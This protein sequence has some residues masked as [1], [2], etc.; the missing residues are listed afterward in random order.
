MRIG[1]P[2]P[3]CA[4]G[5]I[6]Q[7]QYNLRC[8]NCGWLGPRIETLSRPVMNPPADEAEARN[9]VHAAPLQAD[10]PAERR[11][12]AGP[13][14]ESECRPVMPTG[15]NRGSWVTPE[16]FAAQVIQNVC[17]LPDYNSPDDQPDLLQ[18]TVSELEQCVMS[19]FEHFGSHSSGGE[20]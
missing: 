16:K 10:S 3:T 19:A 20:K 9:R 13:L 14:S 7:S 17:E 1:D 4:T 18:C 15:L 5:R 11:G 6:G 12:M 2:C 8:A